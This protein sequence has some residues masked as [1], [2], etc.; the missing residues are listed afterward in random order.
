MSKWLIRGGVLAAM[1]VM[2]GSCESMV[3]PDFNGGVLN[4]DIRFLKA[5]EVMNGVKCAMT[6][7]MRE[8]ELQVY[9]E[10]FEIVRDRTL[11]QEQAAQV[12]ER[13]KF[14]LL[15]QSEYP[16]SYTSVAARVARGDYTQPDWKGADNELSPYAL[17]TST[18]GGAVRKKEQM[19]CNK[20]PRL[21]EDRPIDPAELK[22][23]DPKYGCV[24]NRNYCPGQL[25]V[26]LWDYEAKDADGTPSKL[27][28]HGNCAPV[29]DYSRFALDRSQLA[30]ID[31]TLKGSN[32]GTVFYSMIDANG[33]G[34]LQEIITPG[35][36]A[37]SAVFPTA[38]FTANGTTTF[39][40]QVQMPQT[41]FQTPP[42]MGAYL[43]D[44]AKLSAA[45][46]RLA[47]HQLWQST[48]V[49]EGTRVIVMND[50]EATSLL[51]A[52]KP[53][54]HSESQS[55]KYNY[56]AIME[57]LKN[58]PPDKGADVTQ[59]FSSIQKHPDIGENTR[60]ILRNI[61]SEHLRKREK[62]GKAGI[63]EL[64]PRAGDSSKK[65]ADLITGAEKEYIRNNFGAG[66]Q[67]IDGCGSNGVMRTGDVNEI[68]YLALK[69]MLL[70]VVAQ[71][72]EQ[73]RY[74][75]GPEIFLDQLTLTT[76]FQ[77]VFDLSAGTKGIFRIFPMVAPP[78][79]GVKPDHTHT[80]KIVLHGQKK[81]AD[82]SN[83]RNLTVSCS[84]RLQ[85]SSVRDK[86]GGRAQKV[87]AGFCATPAGQMLES[88]IEATEQSKGGASGGASAAQ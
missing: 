74:S 36:K 45:S 41:I 46:N 60:A 56:G 5:G 33:L 81:K 21:G 62:S 8:R 7:F 84:Q 14:L 40:M 44:G 26:V 78:Q 73:V 68:D 77:I 51:E 13:K 43:A 31:L 58:R 32:Q 59:Y 38:N 2:L 67:F 79:M 24:L 11:P 61:E 75:G 17:R 23:W 52:I 86:A 47:G 27:G 37:I 50:K 65:P 18:L 39:D 53:L 6:A 64:D 55:V 82:P 4:P 30:A 72:N 1:S 83:G 15:Y 57:Q 54:E 49:A 25:G 29:P 12:D 19:E 71:Q 20:L 88:I 16:K 34:V 70:K 10:R 69:D 28:G 76:S 35:N 85:L 9:M 48:R 42:K 66:N 87:D 22:H 3:L 80:L 63:R